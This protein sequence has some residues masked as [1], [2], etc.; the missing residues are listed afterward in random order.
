MVKI[1]KRTS[2]VVPFIAVLT[3]L[4]AN[5]A[6]AFAT[7]DSVEFNSV[8]LNGITMAGMVDDTV[9][10]RV[11][12][13]ATDNASNVELEV[14]MNGFRDDVSADVKI[15]DVEA[16]VTYVKTLSLSLPDDTDSLSEEYTLY[17]ELTTST[18]KVEESYTVSLQRESHTLEILSVDLDTSV[19]A[20]ETVPV[21]VV[22]KNTGYNREDDVYVTVSIP[23]L[24]VSQRAYVEDLVP[25][26]NCDD[27]CD[28]EDTESQVVYVKIPADAATGVYDIKV[29]AYSDDAET[30]ETSSI[31]VGGSVD[32]SFYPAATSKTLKAGETVSYDLVIVNTADNVKTYTLQAVSGD[33]LTVSVPSIVVV[34][35]RDS[36]IV[37]VEVTADSAARGDYTFSVVSDNKQVVYTANVSGSS[38]SGAIVALTVALVIIF[39]VL[40]VVLIVL[41]TKKG[42]KEV[43]EVETSYY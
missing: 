34:G 25:M 40:L 41:A 31:R 42:S 17:V 4:L 7:V 28:H 13:T 1:M 30:T 27:D 38:M 9:P 33:D 14:S 24:D 39:L 26:E 19:S 37:S 3:L 32:S 12:F 5:F 22:V 36:A 8:E 18:D 23:S 29:K 2:F 6:V 43:E 16:G 20:G 11:V 15:S 10:I 21:T 35:P